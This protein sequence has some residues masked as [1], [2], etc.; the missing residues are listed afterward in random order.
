V[1]LGQLYRG[2]PAYPVL[3][4]PRAITLNARKAICMYSPK[5]SCQPRRCWKS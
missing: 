4:Q 2:E 5:C 1:S 3:A